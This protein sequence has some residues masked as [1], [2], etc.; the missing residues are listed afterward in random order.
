MRRFI[1]PLLLPVLAGCTN[2]LAER[3]AY[4]N[5]F[6]GWPENRL[7]RYLGV[8]SRTYEN[9][10]Q[11]LLAYTESR[12]DLQPGM[13]PMGFG[14]W[15]GGWYGGGFPPQV[16]NRVCETTFAIV[17]DKVASFTLRGNACG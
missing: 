4:L 2:G 7:V 5:Q 6:I 17:D 13:M 11:R 14:P 9:D 15:Y 12:I 1:L 16:V 8:P 10:G 3:E